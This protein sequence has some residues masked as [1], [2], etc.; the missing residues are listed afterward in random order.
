MK[1]RAFT[2]IELLVV[3]L[4][5]GILAAIALP[6]Y[7]IAVQKARA[8]QDMVSVNGIV[9]AL[10]DYHLANNTWPSS[11]N[12]LGITIPTNCSGWKAGTES[13]YYNIADRK[14]VV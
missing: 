1:N 7:R 5:I 6:Q 8:A 2:L 3:V 12:D 10:K 14:S 4:I 9:T 11:L 13:T